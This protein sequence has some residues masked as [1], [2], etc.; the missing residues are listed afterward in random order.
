MKDKALVW[1]T[2]IISQYDVSDDYD[3]S[4]L[5]INLET[6]EKLDDEYDLVFIIY[7]KNTQEEYEY[8]QLLKRHRLVVP[9][10]FVPYDISFTE[11]IHGIIGNLGTFVFVDYSK[12]RLKEVSSI[13][14]RDD[15][16]HVSKLLN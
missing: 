15:V 9:V 6:F 14:G 4:S 16:V 3:I 10:A 7:I 8:R 2:G 12:S 1:F 13:L 5:K 11:A